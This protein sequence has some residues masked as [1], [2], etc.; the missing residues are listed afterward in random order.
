MADSREIVAPAQRVWAM[1]SDLPHMGQWS[2]E[3]EG[4]RWLKGD[5]GAVVSVFRGRNRS[6]IRRWSTPARVIE[7]E[8]GKSFEIVITFADFAVGNWRHDFEDTAEGLRPRD[9]EPESARTDWSTAHRWKSRA[10]RIAT[11]VNSDR[12][13]VASPRGLWP[14]SPARLGRR[15]GH[16]PVVF[17][18][19]LLPRASG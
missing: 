14:A 6:G 11:I 1:V 9:T 17:G 4:G 18:S 8:P 3:N 19:V 10:G 13:S 5:G 7:S 12:L 16:L 2:P 15:D